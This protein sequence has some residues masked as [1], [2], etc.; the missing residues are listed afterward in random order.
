MEN[1]FFLEGEFLCFHPYS[2]R[3]LA[4]YILNPTFFW[5]RILKSR[6]PGS[7]RFYPKSHSHTHLCMHT[8]SSLFI[9]Q[10]NYKFHFTFHISDSRKYTSL[11]FLSP[12]LSPFQTYQSWKF[13]K[14]FK[15]NLFCSQNLSENTLAPTSSKKFHQLL[16][17]NP[18]KFSIRRQVY[19]RILRDM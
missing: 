3:F 8:L 13:S 15:F 16:A 12:F 4:S 17:G 7:I 2:T 6:F 1:S 11:N 9:A 10:K 19:P 18:S 5:G 14:N